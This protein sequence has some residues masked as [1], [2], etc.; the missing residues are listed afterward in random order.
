MYKERDASEIQFQ[1][2][3]LLQDLPQHGLKAGQTGTV[4]EFLT[5]PQE[6]Y[7][8]EFIDADGHTIALMTLE[9]K[10]ITAANVG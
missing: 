4:L 3:A 9:E 8:V 6:G 1:V 2:V 7:E 10:Q 5:M